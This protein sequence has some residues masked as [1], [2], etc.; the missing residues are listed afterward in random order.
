MGCSR[1]GRSQHEFR[2]S[3]DVSL[4]QDGGEDQQASLQG[5]QGG[6][7]EGRSREVGMQERICG[8]F[9][10]EPHA[11]QCAEE[12]RHHGFEVE[13]L[14]A[15]LSDGAGDA[16]VLVRCDHSARLL[17][18]ADLLCECG[19]RLVE[20]DVLSAPRG[21]TARDPG[22]RC[23]CSKGVASGNGLGPEL[24]LDDEEDLRD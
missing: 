14:P 9:A 10:D 1:I 19:A 22:N 21:L 15:F 11:Q 16:A 12:L 24:S 20:L 3:H 17:E 6:V 23:L 2:G 7:V 4:K 5:K 18:A 13:V 8:V